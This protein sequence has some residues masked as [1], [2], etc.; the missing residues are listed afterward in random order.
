[1]SLDV[2]CAIPARNEVAT[3]QNVA[4]IADEGLGLLGA[5]RTHLLLGD[6]A[7]EDG[8]ADQFLSTPTRSDK[9]VV[10]V[11]APGKG[12]VVFAAITRAL[13]LEASHVVFLDADLLSASPEWV[14]AL[15]RA[16]TD[17]EA[18]FA[19][20]QYVTSQGG[21]LTNLVARPLVYHVTGTDMS[22]P[23]GGEMCLSGSFAATVLEQGL[24][25]AQAG[26]G[27][28]VH[29]SLHALSGLDRIAKVDLGVKAHR[30]R[31]WETIQPIVNE[32][33]QSVRAFLRANGQPPHVA[34]VV[35]QTSA[36]AAVSGVRRAIPPEAVLRRAADQAR[37]EYT[38]DWGQRQ[39]WLDDLVLASR[40]RAPDPVWWSTALVA[41]VSASAVDDPH[42]LAALECLFMSG[43]ASLARSY[44]SDESAGETLAC[45]LVQAIDDLPAA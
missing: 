24:T 22:Q 30:H 23:I 29:I 35:G 9:A 1:M 18:D 10:E 21:P 27:I 5:A 3:I 4:R 38:A 12:N 16:C 13:E 11:P 28:D 17:N 26:Y 32:V 2:V 7:S 25:Q 40:T 45:L 33:F 34:R 14:P 42:L 19:M 31:S 43:A 8:T 36:R 15:L 6:N 41:L 37:E 20:P 44:T 39:G